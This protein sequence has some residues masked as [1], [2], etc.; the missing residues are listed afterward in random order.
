MIGIERAVEEDLWTEAVAFTRERSPASFDQWFSGVQYDG[1][2]D[3]VLSLRA[4]DE[5]RGLVVLESVGELELRRVR[6]GFRLRVFV[7]GLSHERIGGYAGAWSGNR[8]GH[9]DLGTHAVTAV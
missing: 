5:F 9:V 3:G 7:F 4:R 1:I 2:V 6:N 8:K